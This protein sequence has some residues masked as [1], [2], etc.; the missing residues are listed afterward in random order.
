MRCTPASA[1]S[2]TGRSVDGRRWAS[3]RPHV[4]RIAGRK[5]RSGSRQGLWS[6]NDR[7]MLISLL[8]RRE[9]H[10]S[11]GAVQL[12]FADLANLVV[13]TWTFWDDIVGLDQVRKALRTWALPQVAGRTGKAR[14]HHRVAQHVRDLV[15]SVAAPTV[16]KSQQYALAADLTREL[17]AGNLH[18][19][20]GLVDRV[21]AVID[22]DA[23]GRRVGAP[24]A[25]IDA[26]GQIE[27]LADVFRGAEAVIGQDHVLNEVA[28]WLRARRVM[29]ASWAGYG[30]EWSYLRATASTPE[31]FTTP[32]VQLQISSCSKILLTRLGRE[33]RAL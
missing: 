14:S 4:P 15:A 33:L 27:M 31:L 32:D 19:L 21:D 5:G 9:A 20:D 23:T 30:F 7:Q 22:P 26:A 3:S 8:A 11:L 28:V 24:G 1:A 18:A 17:W 10:R 6:D 16:P 29:R 25:S 13:W 2:P 12:T